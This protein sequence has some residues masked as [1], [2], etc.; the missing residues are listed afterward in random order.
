MIGVVFSIFIGVFIRVWSFIRYYIDIFLYKLM[1]YRLNLFNFRKII[2]RYKYFI[3]NE[4]HQNSYIVATLKYYKRIVLLH[5]FHYIRLRYF[6]GGFLVIKNNPFKKDRFISLLNN[7]QPY[8]VFHPRLYYYSRFVFWIFIEEYYLNYISYLN[9]SS[10]W[11]KYVL[12][13]NIF[14]LTLIER[15]RYSFPINSFVVL[16]VYSKFAIWKKYVYRTSTYG[17]SQSVKIR[18]FFGSVKN[19]NLVPVSRIFI[20][21]KISKFRLICINIV[22]LSILLNIV[23]IF[24]C[25]RIFYNIGIIFL[26]IAYPFAT[27]FIL[28]VLYRNMIFFKK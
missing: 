20:K 13:L 4:W 8:S 7:L 25:L 12:N 27:V 22:L 2:S 18:L 28:L 16:K 14:N 1:L 9:K 23:L 10:S 15:Y 26:L 6:Y 24:L 5:F 3:L 19:F 17:I 11:L 21:S